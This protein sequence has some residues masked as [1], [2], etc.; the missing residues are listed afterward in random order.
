MDR[1]DPSVLARNVRALRSLHGLSKTEYSFRAGISRDTL[2]RIENGQGCTLRIEQKIAKAFH[3]HPRR[4]W[5]SE[6][7]AIGSY[8]YIPATKNRWAFILPEEV[9]NYHRRLE[10]T[11]GH[12]MAD[13]FCADPDGIQ[14]ETER[15]RLGVSGFA[16]AFSKAVGGT[17]T[18]GYCSAA[19]IECYQKHDMVHP[20]STVGYL[21][22]VIRGSILYEQEDHHQEVHAGDSLVLHEEYKCRISPLNPVLRGELCPLFL[23]SLQHLFPIGN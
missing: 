13:E 17:V 8:K 1:S 6:L 2:I 23:Y 22:Y 5:D 10:R 18:S 11:V 15:Q 4:L 21:V 9:D 20:M 16:S 19:L 3:S 14:E 7:F 12:S